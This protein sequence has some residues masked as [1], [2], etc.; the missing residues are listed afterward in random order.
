MLNESEDEGL[1]ESDVGEDDSQNML[2][3]I[4]DANEF[5]HYSLGQC[6]PIWL[7]IGITRELRI[8]L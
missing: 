2:Y 1:A 7:H 6:F 3:F 4:C 8:Y 5:G